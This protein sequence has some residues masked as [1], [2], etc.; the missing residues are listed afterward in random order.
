MKKFLIYFSIILVI[1]LALFFYFRYTFVFGEGTKAGELNFFVKKGYVWKTYEGRLI[2]TGY[3][4]K[5]HYTNAKSKK[6]S[7]KPGK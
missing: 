5:A 3:K 1:S 7:G 2:Q 6:D 4:S